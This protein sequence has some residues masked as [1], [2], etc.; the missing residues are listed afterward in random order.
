VARSFASRTWNAVVLVRSTR[1]YTLVC[2]V[3]DLACPEEPTAY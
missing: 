2:G 1:H 3:A